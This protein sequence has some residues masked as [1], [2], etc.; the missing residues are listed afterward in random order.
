MPRSNRL[1]AGLWRSSLLHIIG[2][3]VSATN[4]DTIT[5][6]ASVNANS[7]NSRPVRPG[8]NASG[9]NTAASV[10]V[11]ATTAKLISCAPLSA[12]WNGSSPSSMW[13]KMFSSTTI[14]SSTTS[15]MASTSA[16]S[17]SVLMV[18]PAAA[19]SRTHRSG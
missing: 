7:L 2:V 9:A 10:S 5:A 13:R 18:N 11:I 3:S 4:P 1:G 16:S 15:P 14:A 17:V 6:P 19:M 12:A 8:V